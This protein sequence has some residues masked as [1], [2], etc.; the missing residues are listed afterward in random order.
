MFYRLLNLAYAVIQGDVHLKKSTDHAQSGVRGDGEDE[1]QGI[2]HVEE[3]QGE[4]AG[5][6]ILT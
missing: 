4:N 3:E 2:R 5:E 6:M 1:T